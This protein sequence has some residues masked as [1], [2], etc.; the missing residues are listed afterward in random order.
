MNVGY[1]LC[2]WGI[3]ELKGGP[4]NGEVHCDKRCHLESLRAS[5][6][7]REVQAS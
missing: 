7:P 5:I 4:R 3:Q 1:Y 2:Y 6:F